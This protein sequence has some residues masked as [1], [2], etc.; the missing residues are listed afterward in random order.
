MQRH[1]ALSICSDKTFPVPRQPDSEGFQICCIGGFRAGM[2][3]DVCRAIEDPVFDKG[4]PT[5]KGFT[6]AQL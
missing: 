4:R 2:V 1:P 6:K 3:D 5:G